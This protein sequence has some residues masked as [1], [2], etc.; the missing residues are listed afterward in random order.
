MPC[1][2]SVFCLD[3]DDKSW[4][5][6][7]RYR[8]T[9][10]QCLVKSYVFYKGDFLDF[11][12]FICRPSDSTVLEDAGIESR[13]VATL[14]LTARR[15]SNHSARSYTEVYQL[16][17]EITNFLTLQ[18]EMPTY[19]LLPSPVTPVP[20]SIDPVFAK[21]SLKRLFS[22]TEYEHFGLVFTKTRVYKFGHRTLE[23]SFRYNRN[24]KT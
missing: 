2:F 14:A 22:M 9:N 20:E 10:V 18:I 21:T 4:R 1:F 15:R 24:R 11:F 13:T 17:C 19:K 3:L 12:F 7:T 6:A 5:Q 16:C 23:T 8:M